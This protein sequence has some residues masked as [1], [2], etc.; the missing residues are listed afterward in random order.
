VPLSSW[1]RVPAEAEPHVGRFA[2]DLSRRFVVG[3][4]RNRGKAV[5]LAFEIVR[6]ARAQGDIG[7]RRC[8]P[9]K[10]SKREIVAEIAGAEKNGAR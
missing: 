2:R 1:N 5:A 9:E 4:P 3:K 10:P 7:I 8:G 6:R